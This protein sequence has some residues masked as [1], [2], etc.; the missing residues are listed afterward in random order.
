MEIK[1][2]TETGMRSE[3]AKFIITKSRNIHDP[4]EARKLIFADVLPPLFQRINLVRVFLFKTLW[5]MDK[6]FNDRKYIALNCMFKNKIN[7]IHKD[8]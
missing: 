1:K 7:S 6:K 3:D 5:K 4:K 2:K 8:S